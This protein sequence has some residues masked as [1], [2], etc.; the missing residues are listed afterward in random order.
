MKYYSVVLFTNSLELTIP[1]HKKRPVHHTG[2]IVT[3]VGVE[4]FE[5]PAPWSQTTYSTKLSH[6][7]LQIWWREKDSNLRRR[8]Q[9]IYSPSP[10]AARDP[11]HRAKK[12]AP[13]TGLEPV[14][15]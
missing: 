10:L 11:L 4:G 2:R 12:M 7:P 13:Q 6:T 14:T 5:P 3:T 1:E 8:S 15:S 9:R